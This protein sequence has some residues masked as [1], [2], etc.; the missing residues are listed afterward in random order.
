MLEDTDD[1]EK[2]VDTL[3]AADEALKRAVR[4][5]RAVYT[6]VTSALARCITQG[7]RNAQQQQ[8]QQDST[9]E[10]KAYSSTMLLEDGVFVTLPS[11][12]T[13]F[14][15]HAMFTSLHLISLPNII[16]V[17]MNISVVEGALV[18]DSSS[19]IAA[20]L[21]RRTLRVFHG[22]E[23]HIA[24]THRLQEV[25]LTA[26]PT[27]VQYVHLRTV[28]KHTY[29]CNGLQLYFIYVLFSKLSIHSIF[30]LFISMLSAGA[31]GAPAVVPGGRH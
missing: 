16:V 24:H 18:V 28:C 25:V 22:T 15:N 3:W 17:F 27:Q 13:S 19:A 9:A 23:R 30:L 7:H 11:F 26:A 2:P 21:L 5:S 6:T 4:D 1:V 29:C 10:G 8:Q 31:G 12:Y 20:S 14:F